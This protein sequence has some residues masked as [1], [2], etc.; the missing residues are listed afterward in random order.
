MI[1]GL[2][3]KGDEEIVA[4]ERREIQQLMAGPLYIQLK[5]E[6]LV[7]NLPVMELPSQVSFITHS[8]SFWA[9]SLPRNSYSFL[10]VIQLGLLFKFLVASL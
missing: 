5:M 3:G 10:V 6:H 9:E 4:I 2:V 8:S 7:S 1:V